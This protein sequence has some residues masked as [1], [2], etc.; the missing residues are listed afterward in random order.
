[1]KQPMRLIANVDLDGKF[2]VAG[3]FIIVG[4]L[5]GGGG[6]RFPMQEMVVQLAA[7]IA[8]FF[9]FRGKKG[10]SLSHR[11][12][13]QAKWV[14]CFLIAIAVFIVVQ[15]IPLPPV[16]WQAIPGREML[17]EASI[18]LGEPAAWRPISIDPDLTI[19]SSLALVVPIASF[20]IVKSLNTAQQSLLLWLVVSV[21]FV[22]LI[23]GGMQAFSGGND[24]YLYD[25]AHKGLPI[26]LFGNR[27]HM[28]IMLLLG[29]ILSVPLICHR[30]EQL[31]FNKVAT[32]TFFIL[33]FAFGIVA[34]NSRSVAVLATLT[35]SLIAILSVPVKQKRSG[36][37]AVAVIVGGLST[38]VTVMS[39]NGKFGVVSGLAGRF[40]QVG[41]HR[42]EFW[43]TALTTL[44]HYF[45]FGSGLG[46]FD[47]AFRT[48]EKLEVLG[49][50]Y[51]NHAHNEYLEVGIEMGVLGIF[52]LL[53]SVFWL[54]KYTI[55]LIFR[56]RA[57]GA[58]SLPSFAG[59]G[60]IC[61]ALHSLVDYPLR[62]LSIAMISGI[63]VAV[64]IS[65]DTSK[66]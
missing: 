8:L 14:V 7:V 66:E 55:Q 3:I 6:S 9:S 24:F 34:T 4:G 46:T 48:Q 65:S 17:A 16:L 11:D 59:Y 20:F 31:D 22:N 54:L 12:I 35:I 56:Y 25:T 58:S 44:S 37:I 18:L 23:V 42:Y 13:R 26:G 60:L 43:P 1:M 62:S 19:V 50:H 32:M 29:M 39:A 5:L 40:D 15:L 30:F 28:G 61:L 41:D 63:L 53:C 64:M 10:T 21:V 57:E 33:T 47:T 51:V 27:N 45:P 49:T 38:L 36:Y 2:I 52:L